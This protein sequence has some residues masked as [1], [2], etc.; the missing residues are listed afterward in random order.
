MRDLPERHDLQ[1]HQGGLGR[2][3]DQDL[4]RRQDQQRQPRETIADRHED[5][6]PGRQEHHLRERSG[7]SGVWNDSFARSG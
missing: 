6:G 4:V 7:R 1:D 5:L 3:R 2:P